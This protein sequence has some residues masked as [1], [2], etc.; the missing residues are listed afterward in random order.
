MGTSRFERRVGVD[1]ASKSL[2]MADKI[3]FIISPIG[4]AGSDIRKRSDTIRDHII[5]PALAPLDY[6]I[7]RADTVNES[8]MITSQIVQRIM[9]SALVIA[10][11]TDRNPNVFYELAIRHATRKPFIQ[12][13]RDGDPI[14]FDVAGLRTI[15]VDIHDLGSAAEARQ[16]INAQASAFESGTEDLQTPISVAIDLQ[17]L[18]RSDSP[19]HQ[20]LA[21]ILSS[22]SGLKQAVDALQQQLNR[23]TLS[24][25]PSPN[26]LKIPLGYSSNYKKVFSTA[27][28][29][30]AE[31]FLQHGWTLLST[32]HVVGKDGSIQID[33]TLGWPLPSEPSEPSEEEQK[34]AIFD[35]I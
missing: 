2:I 28:V 7:E 13:I 10:D 27:L 24:V 12:L 8:G 16:S 21:D 23:R 29:K 30:R 34:Q 11:L 33:Y 22:L 32:K 19:E 25:L 17:L 4:D 5:K 31:L 18:R 26:I 20:S 3:C 1:L 9:D 35:S 15:P 6:T 14:P